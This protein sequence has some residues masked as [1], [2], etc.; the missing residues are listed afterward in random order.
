A[1]VTYPL[2]KIVTIAACATI[3][4]ADDFVAMADW[5][6]QHTDWLGRGLDLSNGV[7]SYDRLNM[8]LRR[9]DRLGSSASSVRAR[10]SIAARQLTRSRRKRAGHEQ[11]AK[12]SWRVSAR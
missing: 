2:I 6:R 1:Q 8:V 5:A 3:A 10:G 12:C 11:V 7:P 4:G 9:L